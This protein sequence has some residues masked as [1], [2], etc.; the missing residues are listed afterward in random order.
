M[1]ARSGLYVLSVMTDQIETLL[2]ETRRFPP[3]PAFAARAQAT[4]ATYAEAA[5]DRLAFWAAR[6][7]ELEWF[8]PWHTVLDWQLP[9]AR[10]FSG[11]TLNASVN[12]LDRHI[13][14]AKRNPMVTR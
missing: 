13:R 11:G 5:T 7:A 10:W 12:C 6:A 2:N 9:H 3:D 14:G 1:R 4:A 8:T